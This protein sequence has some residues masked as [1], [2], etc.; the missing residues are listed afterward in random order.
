MAYKAETE[1]AAYAGMRQ[2]SCPSEAV[3]GLDTHDEIGGRRAGI[4]ESGGLSSRSGLWTD[5]L[6]S[7]GNSAQG[8]HVLQASGCPAWRA[9]SRSGYSTQYSGTISSRFTCPHSGQWYRRACPWGARVGFLLAALTTVGGCRWPYLHRFVIASVSR[10]SG[11]LSAADKA[12]RASSPKRLWLSSAFLTAQSQT[13]A[14]VLCLLPALARGS[15]PSLGRI[16]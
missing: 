10:P 14:A 13:R 9:L 16:P 4:E 2:F 1:R 11:V 6:F 7:I 12:L 8:K 3:Q 15:L 5:A